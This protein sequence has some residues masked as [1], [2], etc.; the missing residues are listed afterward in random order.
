MT[1]RQIYFLILENKI[2]IDCNGHSLTRDIRNDFLER[3]KHDIDYS[4]GA[5]DGKWERIKEGANPDKTDSDMRE[6]YSSRIDRDISKGNN[7]IRFEYDS[8]CFGCG[9]KLYWQLV[10]NK[11][12]ANHIFNYKLKECFVLMPSCSYQHIKEL[13]AVIPNKTGKFVFANYFNFPDQPEKDKWSEEWS[14]NNTCGCDNR[15]KYKAKEFGVGYGQTDNTSVS[16]FRSPDKK[17]I[18]VMHNHSDEH[19]DYEYMGQISC[20]VWRYE[21][22]DLSSV[23]ESEL[24]ED[25]VIVEMEIGDYNFVHPI[26]WDE[27]SVSEISLAK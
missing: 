27:E 17:R 15:M 24:P 19:E 25:H 10:D 21:F 14:L 1:V 8:H 20:D 2:T 13:E 18:K 11:L 6:F 22:V 23:K 5:G 9:E 12:I 26:R 3:V 4:N 16:I 7:V